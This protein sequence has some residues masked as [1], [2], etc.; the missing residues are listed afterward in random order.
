MQKSVIRLLFRG[1]R[2]RVL[3]VRT[4]ESYMVYV[5]LQPNANNEEKERTPSS[6]GAVD[7]QQAGQIYQHTNTWWRRRTKENTGGF[8]QNSEYYS[9]QCCLIWNL[10]LIFVYT[11]L[12]VAHAIIL[13]DLVKNFLL[14]KRIFSCFGRC[15]YVNALTMRFNSVW[16]CKA[17][18]MNHSKWHGTNYSTPPPFVLNRE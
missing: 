8:P 10:P 15:L 4:C 18:I 13:F 11:S 6:P 12:L 2:F 9:L 14:L 16:K 3:W 1:S 17:M 7:R 5:S